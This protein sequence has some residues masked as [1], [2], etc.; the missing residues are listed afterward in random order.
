M[1]CC[2]KCKGENFV[3]VAN[4]TVIP[5]LKF[6]LC[7]CGNVMM[8]DSDMKGILLPT[9][10][11]NGPFTKLMMEDASKAFGIPMSLGYLKEEDRPKAASKFAE[12][13]EE[14]FSSLL[15]DEEYDC[16]E[17]GECEDCDDYCPE[18]DDC[19][20]YCYCDEEDDY[21]E[22][23]D[24][25]VHFLDMIVQYAD[26]DPEFTEVWNDLRNSGELV[27]LV[28]DILDENGLDASDLIAQKNELVKMVPAP[29]QEDELLARVISVFASKD[30]QKATDKVRKEKADKLTAERDMTLE[31]LVNAAK[32]LSKWTEKKEPVV[33]GPQSLLEKLAVLKATETMKNTC[34]RTATYDDEIEEDEEETKSYVVLSDD[35]SWKL[36]ENMTKEEMSEALNEDDD[37]EDFMIYEIKDVDMTGRVQFIL[38]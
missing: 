12:M 29:F 8:E 10:E 5:T 6:Y 14:Y 4:S 20:C 37:I 19:S 22:E 25:V 7:G 9:P 32:E 26:T 13:L 16:C 24:E 33:A 11:D 18:C 28:E 15:D 36:Y 34:E 30:I 21:A 2:S 23:L 38:K 31:E 1:K 27:N 3:K 35:G 17:D